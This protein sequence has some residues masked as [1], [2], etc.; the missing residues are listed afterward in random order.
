VTGDVWYAPR[1]SVKRALAAIETARGNAQMD[2]AC[3]TGTTLVDQLINRPDGALVPTIATRSF[4]YPT[5]AAGTRLYL[6]DIGLITPTSVTAGGT[7]LT[8]A[9]LVFYPLSGPPYD[10]V[11][12]DRSTATSLIHSTTSQASVDVAGL[13]GHTDTSRPAG[14][15]AAAIVTTTATSLTL[16]G[17]GAVAA[18]VGSLLRIDSERMAVT[19]R[20]WALSGQS[21]GS[22]LTASLNG[23]LLT[24]ATGASFTIGETVLI[25]AERCL[26]EDI[27]ADTLVIRR[28]W[29]GSTLAAHD[30]ATA[31]Y[32]SRSLTVT[33]GEAGTIAATHL[34]GAA[35]TV[36]APPPLAA[37]LARAE[38]QNTVLQEQSGYTRTVGSGDNLRNASG[39]GIATL[40]K[41]VEDAYGYVNLVGTV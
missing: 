39:A 9:D 10:S 30:L 2:D 8:L 20:G 14:A 41:Q 7:A 33:R 5:N 25:G 27:A 18:G 19:E 17:P 11:E 4:D 16:T 22:A 40:R 28:A 1:E 32:V 36:W 34:N 13:W 21:T 24:V 38:A 29:D 35:A 6:G 26:I 15:L 23:S 3:R 37:A 12:V 31:I